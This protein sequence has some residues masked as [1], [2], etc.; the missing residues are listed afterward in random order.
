MKNILIVVI[1]SFFTFQNSILLASNEIGE[2]PDNF[3]RIRIW[4][5]DF[6]NLEAGHVSLET[7]N[8]YI[9]FWPVSEDT[10]TTHLQAPV[11]LGDNRG[12]VRQAPGFAVN[13]Y[14]IDFSYE[15]R[16]N[17]D[18]VYHVL[19]NNKDIEAIWNF[20]KTFGTI[21][22]DGVR[23]DSIRW[24]APGRMDLGTSDI[25]SESLYFNCASMVMLA[26]KIGGMEAIHL[27]AFNSEK[28]L[29]QGLAQMIGTIKRNSLDFSE[30]EMSSFL[31]ENNQL[32]KSI[33]PRDVKS[34]LDSKIKS[35]L[36]KDLHLAFR[37][38][39]IIPAINMNIAYSHMAKMLSEK[40]SQLYKIG[41]PCLKRFIE[42]ETSCRIFETTLVLPN[43]IVTYVNDIE[44]NRSIALG[45]TA[46]AGVA[47]IGVQAAQGK[48]N[49]M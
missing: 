18:H 41:Q 42:D 21:Q 20:T 48:C 16:R 40:K 5:T 23:F 10:S 2:M 37:G 7:K 17:P 8:T 26:L 30:Q 43:G 25:T 9:S 1:I 24:Y 36:E 12:F 11:K 45:V 13:N 39:Q 19:T 38:M 3:A 47:I 31:I 32:A 29:W 14:D 15:N 49:L 28:E 46:A 27:N 35:D 33:L 6:R 4:E 34:I 44:K 22:N